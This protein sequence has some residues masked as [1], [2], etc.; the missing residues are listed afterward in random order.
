MVRGGL[1]ESTNV[2]FKSSSDSEVVK[3]RRFE[4]EQAVADDPHSFY[5]H[6]GLV[7]L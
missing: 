6:G 5:C 3:W 7:F 2:A 1:P 4:D